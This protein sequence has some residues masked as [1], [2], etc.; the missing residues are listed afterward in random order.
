[1]PFQNDIV[2]Y[3]KTGQL[4]LVVEV[5]TRRGVSDAWAAEMRRNLLAHGATQAPYF[6]LALPDRFYLWV[7]K[8][9]LELVNPDY[10]V[11]PL[12]FLKPYLGTPVVSEYLSETGFEM[13]VEA[14]LTSLMWTDE[15]PQD[16]AESSGWLI[17][18]GLFNAL[19][20]GHLASEVTL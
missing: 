3:D 4:V 11:D 12:P 17:E 19:R 18:S 1:M 14:W 8:Q 9:P 20:E 10:V 6:V 13:V 7:D 16:I 5:K 15:L 2:V